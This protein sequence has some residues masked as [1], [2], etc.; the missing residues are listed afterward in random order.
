[1]CLISELGRFPMGWGNG[2]PLCLFK[3]Y[4]E[5]IMQKAQLDESEAE[6]RLSGEI[7]TTSDMQ[8]I[9]FLWQNVRRN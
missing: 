5:C 6:S 3:V 2:N 8:M 4:A 7:T 9:P 1:M